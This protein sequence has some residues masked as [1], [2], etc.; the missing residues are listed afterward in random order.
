[1]V[2]GKQR[3]IKTPH[4]PRPQPLSL[5]G[6]SVVPKT[7]FSTLEG[8]QYYPNNPQ[9]TPNPNLDTSKLTKEGKTVELGSFIN[10]IVLEI[11]C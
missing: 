10:Y 6:I 9:I 7:A 1:M 8:P 5:I 4:G 3:G 11:H 2:K